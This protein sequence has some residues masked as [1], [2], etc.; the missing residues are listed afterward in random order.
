MFFKP[1]L[2]ICRLQTHTQPTFN[3]R[4]NERA[5]LHYIINSK[6]TR[7]ILIAR[8][9]KSY[10][11]AVMQIANTWH[12]FPDHFMLLIDNATTWRQILSK[13]YRRL[14]R[15]F[16]FQQSWHLNITCVGN[17][18]YQSFQAWRMLL[19]LL[20]FWCNKYRILVN[21]L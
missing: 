17:T 4:I 14:I 5:Q 16:Y 21:I 12:F 6:K 13:V 15:S 10:Y 2:D 7:Q 19:G 1:R 3:K 11:L 8:E 18:A 20:L 9:N